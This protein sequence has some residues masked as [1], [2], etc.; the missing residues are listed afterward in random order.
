MIFL[1]ALAQAVTIISSA[2]PMTP[3]QAAAVIQ[4]PGHRA[5]VT[6]PDEHYQPLTP[7]PSQTYPA[8]SARPL[9]SPSRPLNCCTTYVHSP[10]GIWI[11]G[12]QVAGEPHGEGRHRR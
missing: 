2:P 11:D 7:P 12:V 6:T 3:A 4:S 9:P 8:L 1:L 5:N 10:R